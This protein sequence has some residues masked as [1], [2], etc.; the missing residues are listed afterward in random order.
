MVGLTSQRIQIRNYGVLRLIVIFK[1]LLIEQ[2]IMVQ[3]GN[4]IRSAN[5]YYQSQ[6]KNDEILIKRVAVVLAPNFE[7]LDAMGPYEAFKEVQEHYYSLI[8][9]DKHIFG[10]GT[11]IQCSDGDVEVEVVFAASFFDKND[12]SS[13]SV[14]YSSSGVAIVPEFNLSSD[15]EATHFDLL[16]LGAGLD[17]ST[18]VTEYVKKHHTNGGSIMT[19]CTGASILASLGLLNGCE[20]TTNTLFLHEFHDA[21]PSV[22]WIDLSDNLQRRFIRSTEQIIT[23]AGITAGIDGVLYQIKEWCG[24]EV[25]EAT[26]QCLEWPLQIES[27]FSKDE[28]KYKIDSL[29]TKL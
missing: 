25:A 27:L 4:M 26:R 29:T 17:S 28:N 3:A 23:T 13:D 12:D 18:A 15:P 1:L 16:V 20:A 7:M 8:D 19:V 14:I 24:E 21:W 6:P 2:F 5:D 9:I 22:Q 11:G 10:H